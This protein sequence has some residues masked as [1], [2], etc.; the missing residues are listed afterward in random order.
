MAVDPGNEAEYEKRHNPIWDELERT[1]INHGVRS[2]SIF[3]DEDTNTLF[4]YAEIESEEEWNKIGQTE[5]CQKWWS[6]MAPLMPTNE[7]D[8]P[9]SKPLKEVFHIQ[10]R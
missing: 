4:A 8:S 7:D 5:I 3:L 10:T 9:V 6:Y 1:L 2:Y